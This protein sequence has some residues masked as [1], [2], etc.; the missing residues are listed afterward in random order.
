MYDHFKTR[1]IVPD[2]VLYLSQL[3]DS[4]FPV[5]VYLKAHKLSLFFTWCGLE[6]FDEA[7]HLLYANLPISTKS[8]ELQLLVL[9]KQFII[10]GN[11]FE[12]VFG[13]K[14]FAL[15]SYMNKTW[16]NDFEISLKGAKE[17]WLN[18]TITCLTLGPY[19][20]VF[21]VIFSHISWTQLLF[22]EGLN[23]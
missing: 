1:P 8:G 13:T 15:I 10:N 23:D 14:F 22:P 4:H 18:P 9:V 16:P 11:L 2:L 5:S 21:R 7:I 3:K 19:P 20:Y 17:M 6:L 12:D